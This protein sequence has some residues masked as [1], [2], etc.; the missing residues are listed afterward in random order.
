MLLYTLGVSLTMEQSASVSLT[1][2]QSG[3]SSK[4]FGKAVEHLLKKAKGLLIFS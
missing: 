4:S 2:E 1:M 3:S